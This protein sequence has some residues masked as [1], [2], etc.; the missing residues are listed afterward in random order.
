MASAWAALQFL[1]LVDEFEGRRPGQREPSFLGVHDFAA[2]S[3]AAL[4]LALLA[5][6]FGTRGR[7]LRGLAVTAGSRRDPRCRALRRPRERGSDRALAR[8]SPESLPGAEVC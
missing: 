8:R 5:I 2:L 1:G 3:A 7:W 6:A 4:G